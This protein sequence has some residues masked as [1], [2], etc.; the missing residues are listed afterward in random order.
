M[1][2][3]SR[4]K[5]KIRSGRAG[6]LGLFGGAI[7][8]VIAGLV[9]AWQ[10]VEP[11]PPSEI[12]MASGAETGGYYRYAQRYKAILARDGIELE[13]LVTDGSVDNL[14]LLSAQPPRADV[15]L[16]QGGIVTEEQ[17]KTLSGLGSMFYE[18]VWL[19]GPKD[20][21]DVPLNARQGQRIGIGHEKSGTRFI[22]LR[23]LEENGIDASN[24]ELISEQVDDAAA[25]LLDGGLD[26]LFSI[27]A[28]DA[29]LLKR[30]ALDG[31]I[32]VLDLPRAAAYA[33]RFD[34]LTELTLP[35]GALNLQRNVPA[36]DVHLVAS[37]ANLVARP[38]LHP[39]LIGLLLRAAK[40][41]H[42]DGGL[43][44]APGVFPS[45]LKGDF[46]LNAEAARYYESGPPFLQR[47]LPFWAANLI[48]RLKV[49][50][51][52]LV[53]LLLPLFKV[54]PPAYRWR[55]RRRIIRWY[56]ELR[57]IDMEVEES[58]GDPEEIAR[59]QARV[60]EIESEAARVEVPLSYS[61]QLYNLRLHMRLIA[62]KLERR[63]VTEP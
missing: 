52:P 13:V 38:D 53:G 41:V 25:R 14:E 24:A 20:Q 31:D 50:L 26:L 45:P 62:E 6:I 10:F 11:A 21:P 63:R 54:M 7:A 29:P 15:A 8:L 58:S 39:A 3:T 44:A 18:P 49:M 37:T 4:S 9:F 22:A 2:Q 55:I 17:G 57:R 23:M 12:T 1:P 16:V 43:F 19:L 46:P 47:Y 30:L 36:S 61:D 5:A 35:Q 33:L 60:R 34:T 59:L 28:A 56:R 51:L 48:D 40:E 27:G 32:R 42:G